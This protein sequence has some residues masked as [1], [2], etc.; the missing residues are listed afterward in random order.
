MSLFSKS[1]LQGS[2]EKNP[3]LCQEM[4]KQF[5]KY[6]II[7]I[8]LSWFQFHL[9]GKLKLDINW[10]TKKKKHSWLFDRDPYFMV[11]DIIPI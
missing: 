1:D 7:D 11:Y 10:A 8:N 6:S 5:D 2:Y 4:N 3:K 9:V